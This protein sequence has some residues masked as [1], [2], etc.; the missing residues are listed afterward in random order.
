MAYLVLVVYKN[1]F[2]IVNISEV[3]NYKMKLNFQESS[4]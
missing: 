3:A 2:C 4:L 1:M